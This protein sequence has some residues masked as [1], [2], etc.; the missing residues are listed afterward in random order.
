MTDNN[1]LD[2]LRRKLAERGYTGEALE[3]KLREWRARPLPPAI[4]Q[5]WERLKG[6]SSK[7]DITKR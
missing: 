1:F 7:D 6:T 4:T 2:N 3:A 5:L